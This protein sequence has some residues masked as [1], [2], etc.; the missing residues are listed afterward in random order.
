MLTELKKIHFIGIGGSGMSAIA[1]VLL[2]QGYKVSGSD[3]SESEIVQ[4][5]KDLGAKIYKGH[6]AENIIGV[7]AIVV[8]TA[9]AKSNPEVMAAIDNNIPVYH[10]S[11]IVATLLNNERGIAVAGAHGKTTTTSM[12][13]VLLDVAGVDPTAI[14]GGEVDYLQSN[15]K[16]GK[17]EYL[18]AEADESDGSFL[19][20]LPEIA[21]V[22]N[23]ENDHMDYYGT[24]ENILETFKNFLQ[25]LS[26]ESGLAVLCFDN[27]YIRNLAPVIERKFISYALNHDADFM[28]KNIVTDGANTLFDVYKGKEKLGRIKLNVP[29][30]HNVSNALGAIVVCHT[31]GIDIE[32]IQKGFNYFNGAKR[33]F[34]TKGKA[35]GVWVV[36]DYA[37]HPTEINTTLLAARQTNPKRL[38]C[39][40]QP[41][42]YSRTHLLLKE[43]TECFKESDMLV[44]TE[45]YSA[46]EQPIEGVSGKLL[47]ERITSKTQKEV[48]YIEERSKMA[49]YLKGIVRDGDL[50]ITMGA[51][52]IYLTGEELLSKLNSNK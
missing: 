8:S 26:K 36:D 32:T 27:E 6:C 49:E 4:K 52:D 3:L 9:I 10:R 15:A 20:L 46:G 33:R 12:L 38:I 13:A 5:L 48:V 7:D 25:N 47:A 21:I 31:L 22:T 39:A 50:V 43:F 19:K 2:E 44:L 28:A 30:K 14:I 51:G 24:M 45:I 11:D 34:Q 17:G 1:R 18:V 40:F 29:G 42:R 23:I 35:Q 41:H 16:L 37:H